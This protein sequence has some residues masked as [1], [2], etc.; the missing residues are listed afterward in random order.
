MSDDD[1][2]FRRVRF[3]GAHDMATGTYLERVVE[4]IESFDAVDAP[5]TTADA[6]EL[7]NV[8]QYIEN[9]FLP[10]PYTAEQREHAACLVP[11]IHSVVARFFSAVDNSNCSTV[12]ADINFN[13]RADLLELLGRNKAYER[14]D[15]TTMLT[16]LDAAG[17]HVGEMLACRKLV[18]AYQ[19]EIRDELLA[20]PRNAEHLIRKYL[21]S[22]ARR[23]VHLSA[24]LTPS[25]ARDLLERYLDSPEANPNYVRLIE[26]ASSQVTAATGIDA[27]LKLKAKRRNAEMTQKLLRTTR[28]SKPVSR[29]GS[30]TLRANLRSAK[31]TT[32]M[33]Y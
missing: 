16:A 30:P 1:D 5:T 11:K 2:A 24:S 8:Q 17:L 3:F 25:D 33:G 12:V 21:E 19:A 22:D 15:P 4:I 6:I 29:W 13:Y 18:I 32:P 14:C 9:S 28:A 20:S 27:K 26:T 10:H 31:W 23:D 7:H